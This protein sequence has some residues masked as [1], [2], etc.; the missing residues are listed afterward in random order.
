VE[1]LKTSK[2]N[3]TKPNPIKE[4]ERKKGRIQEERKKI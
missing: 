4:E 3:Q 1:I 2:P